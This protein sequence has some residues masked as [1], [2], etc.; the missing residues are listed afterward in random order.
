M[1]ALS[2]LPALATIGLKPRNGGVMRR[3]VVSDSIGN[4]Y[5]NSMRAQPHRHMPAEPIPV[6]GTDP[7]TGSMT[8]ILHS[9]ALVAGGPTCQID[10]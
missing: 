1:V 10:G 2:E 5:V 9:D 7:K 4:L 6:I 8:R 3:I